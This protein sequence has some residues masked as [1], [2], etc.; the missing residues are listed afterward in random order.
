M[1]AWFW[2]KAVVL[3]AA[4]GAVLFVGYVAGASSVSA[5]IDEVQ[6]RQLNSCL[7]ITTS[8]ELGKCMGLNIVGG[9]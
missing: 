3:L 7:P 9:Q 2:V 5:E 6:V 1:K 8:D 4:L